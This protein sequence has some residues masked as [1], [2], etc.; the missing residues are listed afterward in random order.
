VANALYSRQVAFFLPLVIRKSLLRGRTRTARIPLFPGYV[1]VFG[2]DADRLSALQTNRVIA[3]HQ[4]PDGD[5]LRRQLST[6][7][8]LIAA[9]VPLVRESRLTAG[10][11]VRIK[12]GLFRGVEGVILRRH[13]K[14][15]LLVAVDFLG[16]GASLEIDDSI[17]EPV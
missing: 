3:L 17:V 8:E 14:T 5:V 11:R 16:Q 6:L 10:E 12:A 13:G 9:G 1:F 2:N 4:A 7:A 15:E